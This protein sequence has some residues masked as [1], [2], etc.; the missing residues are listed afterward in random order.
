MKEVLKVC[1]PITNVRLAKWE[2]TEK[3]KGFG[4]VDFSR[5]DSAEIAVKKSTAICIRGRPILID[6]ETGKAKAGFKN[7]NNKK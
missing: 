2:H 5:E 1:G 7:F 3:L 6:Y 4:Y